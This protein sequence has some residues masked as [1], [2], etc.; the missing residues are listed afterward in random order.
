MNWTI[1]HEQVYP[2]RHKLFRFALRITGCSLEAEDVVQEVLERVWK[3]PESRSESVSNW[4]AW[5]MSLTR[6]RSL[7]QVRAN[8]RR[9]TLP[10][11]GLSTQP[12]VSDATW[13]TETRD[14]AEQARRLMQ[15]L[16]EKQRM[17]M[18]LRDVEELSYEEIADVLNISM[19]QVKVGLHRARKTIREKMLAVEA[20]SAVD[21]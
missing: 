6:N 1:F 21:A 4:E 20:H 9:R 8:S 3:S 15:D 12:A 14:L 19:E 7:D 18:H 2:I 17:V 10:L 5:C 11:E 13:T 16:P